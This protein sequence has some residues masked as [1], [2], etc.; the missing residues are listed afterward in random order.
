M[1]NFIRY[2]EERSITV[3]LSSTLGVPNSLHEDLLE[4]VKKNSIVKNGYRI[5]LSSVDSLNTS[6]MYETRLKLARKSFSQH[7]RNI[8]ENSNVKTIVDVLD[9]L[10]D[11]HYERVTVVLESVSSVFDLEKIEKLVQSQNGVERKNGKMY[12]FEKINFLRYT[13]GQQ[14]FEQSKTVLESV[15]A[16]NFKSFLSS[17]PEELRDSKNESRIAFK[18]FKNSLLNSLL[19]KNKKYPLVKIKKVSDLRE[20][21]IDGKLFHVGDDVIIEST[22]E[23]GVISMLGPNYVIVEKDIDGTKVRQWLNAVTKRVKNSHV[24]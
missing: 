6:L 22:Q 21:Y 20:E 23:T 15:Y 3:L 19:N 17:L 2:S 11:Q 12:R 5:Y 4:F 1:Y 10:Y 7:A 16:N 8:V 13:K 18:L 14:L 9:H 24:T